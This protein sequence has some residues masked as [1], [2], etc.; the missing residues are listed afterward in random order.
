LTGITFALDWKQ[1]FHA[2]LDRAAEY[3]K[4]PRVVA[5]TPLQSTSPST[6][7]LG[8]ATAA[9]APAPWV[10]APGILM[11]LAAAKHQ[12]DWS[13]DNAMALLLDFIEQHVPEAVFETWVDSQG[14]AEG[15]AMNP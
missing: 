8:V 2:I 13:G 6:H 12:L 1:Q 11:D 5:A 4:I 7:P 3:L 15:A 10:H 14:K 9:S